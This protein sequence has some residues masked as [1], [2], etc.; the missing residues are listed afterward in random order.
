M[1]KCYHPFMLET[2]SN[3]YDEFGRNEFSFRDTE[4]HMIVTEREDPKR[5]AKKFLHKMLFRG[6]FERASDHKI[7]IENKK[8]TFYPRTYKLSGDA[9]QSVMKWRKRQ[10]G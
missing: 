1:L 7:R 6:G 10:H 9:I 5:A 2:L 3:I 4:R 8:R